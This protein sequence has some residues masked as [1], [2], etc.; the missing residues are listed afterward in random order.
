MTRE[1]NDAGGDADTYNDRLFSPGPPERD[2]DAERKRLVEDGLAAAV[3]RDTPDYF[4]IV[5]QAAKQ[6]HADFCVT[7]GI[8]QFKP[9]D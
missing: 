3:H 6:A 9:K 7:H 2:W 4:S 8:P 1:P 5:K